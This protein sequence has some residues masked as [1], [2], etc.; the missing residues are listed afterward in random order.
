MSGG[1]LENW[2]AGEDFRPSALE[3]NQILEAVRFVRQKLMRQ[4]GPVAASLVETSV[5]ILIQ[6]NTTQNLNMNGVVILG[7]PAITPTVSTDEFQIRRVVY[8]ATP[9]GALGDLIGILQQPCRYDDG[10]Q[11]APAVIQGLT[12]CKLLV[13]SAN[14]QFATTIAADVTK[15]QSCGNPAQA[16]I[17]WTAATSGTVDALVL[18]NQQYS[19][20]PVLPSS[21]T[22]NA[23]GYYPG[24]V[25]NRLTNTISAACWLIA[26]GPAPQP[27]HTIF[28]KPYVGTPIGT[29]TDGKTIYAIWANEDFCRTQ[30]DGDVTTIQGQ[31]GGMVQ[32]LGKDA[33][34]FLKLFP[35]AAGGGAGGA[36]LPVGGLL[37]FSGAGTPPGF[38]LAN[39]ASVPVASY[40]ALFAAIGYSYGGSG[41]NFNLPNVSNTTP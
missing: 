27:G 39:G 25:W 11:A 10:L 24:N 4:G 38:L 34:N 7:A 23:N 19:D 5:Q 26:I 37:R 20:V 13:N 35:T 36:A 31:V 29:H 12:S 17:V 33:N 3:H 1:A 2:V 30:L 14:D 16:R 32:L 21:T 6:N 28:L 18:L 40:P 9:D 22:I 15:L 8:G 41:P